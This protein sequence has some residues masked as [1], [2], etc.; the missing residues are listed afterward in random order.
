MKRF[1]NVSAIVTLLAGFITAVIMIV[2]RYELISFLWILVTVMACFYIVSRSIC[3]VFDRQMTKEEEKR[4]E[5]RL[6]QE[7]KELEEREAEQQ[8]EAGDKDKAAAKA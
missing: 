6:E 4:E 1:R 2:N 3:F 5:E 8:N 7:R